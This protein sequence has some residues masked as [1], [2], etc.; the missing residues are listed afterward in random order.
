[1]FGATK[2][3]SLSRARSRSRALLPVKFR[4]D[5][6]MP[7]FAFRL[8]QFISRGDTVYGTIE[9]ESERYLTMSPQKYVPGDGA[10]KRLYPLVFCRE[11]GQEYYNVWLEKNDDGS[12]VIVPREVGDIDQSNEKRTAGFLYL[13]SSLPW[14][15]EEDK[16]LERILRTGFWLTPMSA[17]LSLPTTGSTSQCV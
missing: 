2:G 7:I 16:L 11:T 14:C 3:L 5:L 8:H 12:R 10:L 4:S 6:G 15:F 1:M 13:S 9:A 17:I